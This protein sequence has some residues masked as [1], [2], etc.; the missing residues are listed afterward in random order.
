MKHHY[1]SV[2]VTKNVFVSGDSIICTLLGF[3]ALAN[4]FAGIFAAHE[5][6]YIGRLR[7]II[8]PRDVAFR[9]TFLKN[10]NVIKNEEI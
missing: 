2:C 9:K 10:L 7:F 8:R 3:P 5:S 6:Q 4:Y 1:T